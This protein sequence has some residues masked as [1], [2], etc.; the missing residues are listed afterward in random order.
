MIAGLPNYSLNWTAGRMSHFELTV[1]A[2]ASYF[3]R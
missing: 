3:R 1:P 2:A